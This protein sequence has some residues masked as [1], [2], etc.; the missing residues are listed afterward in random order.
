MG[1]AM[2]AKADVVDIPAPTARATAGILN[3]TMVSIDITLVED[4]A[5]CLLQ[6]NVKR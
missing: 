1:R 4:I 6:L 5:V 2:G 3:L